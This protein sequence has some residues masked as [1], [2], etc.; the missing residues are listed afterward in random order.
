MLVVLRR[1]LLTILGGQLALAVGLTL[2]DSYRRR[3]RKSQPFPTTAPLAVPVGSGEMTTY[4]FGRDVYA[5]MLAAI[6]GANKQILFETY[7][8]KGDE[9]GEEFKQALIEAADRGVDVYVIYDAF[10]NL[11]VARGSSS[12]RMGSGCCAI[13]STTPAGGLST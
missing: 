6:R 3:G 5:D 11:V 13:P 4:T 7:I 2:V 1:T 8:W 10:A 9:V 12:S